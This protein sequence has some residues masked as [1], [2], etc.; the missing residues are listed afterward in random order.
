MPERQKYARAVAT[1]CASGTHVQKLQPVA[2]LWEFAQIF[3]QA[4]KAA[5]PVIFRLEVAR[6]PRKLK[7]LGECFRD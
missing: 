6:D 3:K 4:A 5:A 7:Y 2:F 1:A